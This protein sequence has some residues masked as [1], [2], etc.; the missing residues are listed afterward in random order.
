MKQ[1]NARWLPLNILL[2]LACSAHAQ[3]TQRFS[4]DSLNIKG[5]GTE[6]G[7]VDV[8]R[9]DRMNKGLVTNPLSALNGQAAGV[10][11]S[12]GE[13]RMA[14]LTSVRVRGTTSLTGGNDPLIIIDGVYS[15]LATLSTIYPAD[16]ESFAILRNAAETA[17]YGSRGA[18]GVIEVTTKKGTGAAFH[19]SYDGSWGVEDVYKNIEMLSAAEYVATAKSMGLAYKDDGYN[20]NFFD[21]ITR[22]GFVQNHHVAFSGGGP[23]SSYRASLAYTKNATVIDM[24]GMNNLVAKL[25]ITQNAFDDF[26]NINYGVF[27]SSQ[28]VDGIFDEL[29]L[30][31]S[32]AVQNPTIARDARAKNGAASEINPPRTI[33]TEKNDTK[34]LTFSTHLDMTAHLMQGLSLTLRGSYGFNSTENAQFCPTWLWAQGQAYRGER[35]SESWLANATLDWTHSWGGSDLSLSLLGEYQKDRR[36]GFWTT[37]K[38]FTTN[39]F[40][41]NNLAAGSIRPYG[42]TGSDNADPSLASAMVTATYGLLKRYS[43][44][45]TLR[46]DGSSMVAKHNRWGVFPSVSANWNVLD[47]AFMQPLKPV[48]S[49]LKLRTG[50]GLTGNLGAISSYTT[51]NTVA[52]AGIVPLNGSP[53]MTL[54]SLRN[55]NPDLKWEKKS[56]FN[57]GADMGF[58]RNRILFTI[59]YYYSKTTDMLYQYDVPVP[60]FTYSKLLANIGS[61]ENRGVEIGLGITPLQRRDM[62]LNI[63]VN[64]S[65]QRNKLLSLSGN[66]NGYELSASKVTAIGALTGAGQHGGNADVLY[67]IVGQPLGVFYLPHCKGIVDRGNGYKMYDLEDL[68][69]DGK[70]DLSDGGG[71]RYIAGQ[72]TPKMTLGS[73][74]SF[75]YKAFDIS[76]QMNGAF[77]HKIFNGTSL[78]YLNMSSFP[79]YNVMKGAPERKIVDQNVSDYWLERGDYL[80]FDYLTVGWNV[81]VRNRYI[82]AL[83]LS[84]SVNNL[85]TITSY[86]GLTPMINN[87]IVSNT[88][89][90]D[91]KRS[92]PVYRTWSMGVS[93]QF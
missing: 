12:N 17:Q 89:G 30:F 41:Y 72:A 34:L 48:V 4:P 15:D 38:G 42:G 65:F 77:G 44:S 1:M 26:L 21:A 68:N 88:L 46:A 92:Y 70:I 33:L 58:L 82:S 36:T 9:Q 22:T 56:T 78:S 13:D 59:E 60:P 3:T 16:I 54:V 6:S 19:I 53:T 37:V 90:I 29:M 11:I 49:M 24:K 10:N 27:G 43:L 86:S 25:D 39:D 57:I 7:S 47:E 76:L 40:T 28:K 73:N 32:A 55:A 74:I 69:N 23:T 93:I 31:Y 64:M 66:Y 2:L 62:E 45:A 8:I 87:Y 20:T 75:R 79:D 91:D 71:D 52:P 51:L 35:K 63:N 18:S 85:A 5:L 81:P 80:N 83:R 61:M 84:L 14:Q 67:Q 50:Y